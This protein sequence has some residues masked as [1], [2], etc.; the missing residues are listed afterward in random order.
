MPVLATV[1][2]ATVACTAGYGVLH[3]PSSGLSGLMR[4]VAQGERISAATQSLKTRGKASGPARPAPGQAP[5]PGGTPAPSPS[6]PVPRKIHG[7]QVTA[8][9]DSVMLASAAQLHT[10]LPGIYID[11][12]VSRQMSA[13][14]MEIQR[15][16]ADG[17][18]R[19]VVIVGLGTNGTV[20]RGQIRQLL[21]EI[22]PR[23]RL[24]LVNTYEARPWEHEVNSVIAAAARNYP[25]VVL[26][27]WL[28][29]ITHRTNLLWGDGVH[30]RPP[31]ARLYAKVVAAAV[32]ATGTATAPGS[33]GHLASAPP[34]PGGMTG[35]P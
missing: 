29:T 10:V 23:R 19:Q 16:T 6:G 17:L 11:A 33:A 14:L 22:G 27:N 4:Q 32:Q 31:G 25:N 21:A 15:L 12:H 28:A 26:A 2:A 30:P 7:G 18:L 9:G 3:A 34:R 1:A 13:G 20:T 8:I 5:A 24:I 35:G